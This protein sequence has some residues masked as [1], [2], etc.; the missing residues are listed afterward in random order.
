MKPI[1]RFKQHAYWVDYR[2]SELKDLRIEYSARRNDRWLPLSPRARFVTEFG[3]SPN[4]LRT[5][6]FLFTTFFR[7]PLSF[8]EIRATGWSTLI[9]FSAR[10]S[11]ILLVPFSRDASLFLVFKGNCLSLNL[12]AFEWST[13]WELLRETLCARSETKAVF[14]GTYLRP[15]NFAGLAL[16]SCWITQLPNREIMRTL[17]LWVMR[18]RSVAIYSL[19]LNYS[20]TGLDYWNVVNFL[21]CWVIELRMKFLNFCNFTFL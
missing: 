7:A 4:D 3:L 13:N 9:A 17:C 6:H 11:K 2:F 19:A 21:R 15:A 16:L 8:R 12:I 14:V 20:V 5:S 10:N 18:F 1:K